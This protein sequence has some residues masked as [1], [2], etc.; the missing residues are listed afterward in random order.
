[1]C[2]LSGVFGRSDS[3]TVREM[4]GAIAH[5]GPDDQH[6]EAGKDFT[7]GAR[8]LSILDVE[9]GRQPMSDESGQI[10]AA[11]NG[12]LYN[13]PSCRADLIGRG[14]RLRTRCDTE[15]LTHL[16][17]DCGSAFVN[18]I[19]GM[20]AVVI[21]DD[22]KKTGI[23]A[24]DRM[25]KKPLYYLM[26]DGCLYFASE[27]KALLRVPG[28]ERKVDLEALHHFLSF[29][30]VPNPLSIFADI[31]IL[32]PAHRLVFKPGAEPEISR[33][34]HPDFSPD[35]AVAGL[36][37][38]ATVHEILRLLREGVTKRL[39]SDVPIGFLLSGG[40]D[41]SLSTVLAAEAAKSKIKTFC[42]VYAD[43][44]TTPGKEEDRKWARWVARQY[45]TEH[46]EETVRF[47]NFPDELRK[48]IGAF[49]EPFAG[50][51]STYLLSRLISK[52]VKVAL[53]GDGADELFGSYRSHRLAMP[54]ANFSRY[55]ETGDTA[56][57]RPFE[58]EPETIRALVGDEW[59]WRS[60]MFTFSEDE[61]SALYAPDVAE[62]TSGFSSSELLRAEAARLTARDPVNRILELELRTIFPDQVLTFVDR[63]SMAHSLEL[64]SAYL[65]T[66]L[67]E[68]VARIPGALKLRDGETKHL[69]KR[70]ALKYFPR[71]MVYRRKEGFLMPVTDWLAR[72][73]QGYVR[74]TLAPDRLAKHGFF[75]PEAVAGVVSE[76]YT[77]PNDY[78][79]MNKVFSLLVFQEWY[80]LYVG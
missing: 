9:H 39:L 42:L 69:L 50:V 41:S 77:V 29:K 47:A 30:H 15:I 73:L 10:W 53:A 26:R 68:F 58:S 63:L 79:R 32:P 76:A 59:R 7:I 11:L 46:H 25:G 37:E 45:D 23:L 35:A 54:I 75:R 13:Y 24:R 49:D 28:V 8:R 33:Y 48:I 36:G 72:D 61:K 67:V 57:L 3:A 27:I 34:W 16:Y 71:E 19:D 6:L 44:S 52:H 22:E 18:A 5:R 65:D 43:D 1:M 40:I 14:H 55:E 31:R 60:T 21:W 51:T 64:R 80:E 78:L 12:E 56:L 62:A 4:L 17:Q 2:G 70:A 20:F 74:E 66:A 38:D